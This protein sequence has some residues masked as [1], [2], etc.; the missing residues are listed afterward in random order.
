M[1][2]TI[3]MRAVKAVLS[4][5]WAVRYIALPYIHR[6]SAYGYRLCEYF[7]VPFARYLRYRTKRNRRNKAI[8]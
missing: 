2:E 4:S 8:V 7:G 6:H 5:E 3:V 1:K